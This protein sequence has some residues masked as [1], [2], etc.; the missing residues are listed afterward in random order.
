MRPQF[1]KKKHCKHSTMVAEVVLRHDGPSPKSLD[2]DNFKHKHM[3]FCRNIKICHD[4]CTFWK[5]LGKRS[6]FLGQNSVLGQEMQFYMVSIENYTEL[7]LQICN[8]AQ[9]QCICGETSKYT[10][11]ESFYG[12]FISRKGCQLLPPCAS[13]ISGRPACQQE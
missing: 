1:E 13:H 4:L 12:Y 6:A 9:K 7:N 10:L 3:L 2:L 5:A 8:Y 11:D